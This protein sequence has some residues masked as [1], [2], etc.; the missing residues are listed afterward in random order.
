MRGI[1]KS[2]PGVQA[3]REASFDLQAGEI[4]ALVGENGA[5]KS[6][7][8]KIL[9]G[10]H[11]ADDGDIGLDGRTVRFTSPL[12]SH[13][14][15]IATI[16]QEFTLVPALSVRENLFLG[17]EKTRF[18]M[19]D[20]QLERHAASSV[21]ARLGVEIDPDVRIVDLSLARQQ[22]VEIAR[23]LLADCKILVMD[24]PTAALTPHE[25]ESLFTVLR[26]LTTR[27][28][29]IIFI[30]HRLD[31]VFAIADRITVMRDG[32]TIDTR[33]AVEVNRR[34]LIELMVGRA[35]EDEFPK[36][37]SGC[38][39][40]GFEVRNL[41]GGPVK[42]ISFA[43]RHG[44]VLG[45]AGLMGAGRTET[46]RSIFGA[47]PKTDGEILIDGKPVEIRSPRDAIGHGLCLLT[48]DRKVQGLILRASARDNFSLPNLPRWSRGGFIRQKHES[49]RFAQR[50]AELNIRLSGPQQRA[51]DL[52]GGNQQKL[53][54]A[55]WLESDS[56]V[57]IFDEP[58]RGIDVGA[59][60]EMYLLINALA[61]QEKVIIVIS[62][63]LPEILGISDRILVMRDG[64]VAG[65]IVNV[66]AA[67]QEEIMALA[68]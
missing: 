38:G 12:D 30:S 17:Q 22:L 50:S 5:G 18:G 54:L 48:E 6:T 23:A 62:S 1:R 59:K 29:G 57:L 53:L 34:Q 39:E 19:I 25:V 56:K 27:G 11:Q 61:A 8:I 60:Y 3:I 68:I 41:R 7:L 42:D 26:E 63:E 67:T 10:V 37:R 55:R 36:V 47:D 31:E 4:H 9:T 64:L 40:V 43:V 51:E 66:E 49:Q 45:I 33:K 58:T 21:L 44:E 28:I 35:L 20:A 32:A 14:A 65:E 2:F 24:E 13:R 46:A 15:G 16:Y 52:S